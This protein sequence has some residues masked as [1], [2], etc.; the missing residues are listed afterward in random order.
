MW[1]FER[2]FVFVQGCSFIRRMCVCLCG[3]VRGQN[4]CG[5]ATDARML[6]ELPWKLSLVPGVLLKIFRLHFLLNVAFQ[7]SGHICCL[8]AILMSSQQGACCSLSQEGFSKVSFKPESYEI[9]TEGVIGD[10]LVSSETVTQTPVVYC[11]QCLIECFV[12]KARCIKTLEKS[13]KSGNLI[14]GALRSSLGK[15]FWK[16]DLVLG[17]SVTKTC[18]QA[19]CHLWKWH[20]F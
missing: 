6:L 4:I 1:C 7:L 10:A 16:S 11:R 18:L 3:Y 13:N 20:C 14:T 19:T 15:E 17:V 9:S 12:K 5:E 2:V 8:I